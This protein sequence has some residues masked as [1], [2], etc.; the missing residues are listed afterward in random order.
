[1]FHNAKLCVRLLQ[2]RHYCYNFIFF[3]LAPLSLP[4]LVSTPVSSSTV[5]GGNTATSMSALRCETG[6]A[7]VGS[8]EVLGVVGGKWG[9]RGRGGAVNIPLGCCGS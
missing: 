9:S 2:E 5:S 7:I 3:F 8:D 1:M 4:C 6:V